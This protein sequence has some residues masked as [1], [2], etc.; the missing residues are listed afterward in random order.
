MRRKRQAAAGPRD[1]LQAE[2]GKK[3]RKEKEGRKTA[4]K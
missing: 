4:E 3:K 2:K 1:K